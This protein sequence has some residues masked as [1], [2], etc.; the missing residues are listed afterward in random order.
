MDGGIVGPVWDL[1]LETDGTF[2]FPPSLRADQ[3]E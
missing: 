2:S 3:S 1:L